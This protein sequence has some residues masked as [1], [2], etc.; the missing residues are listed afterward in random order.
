MN[1]NL[2]NAVQLLQEDGVR[3]ILSV[4]K[5]AELI[6]DKLE[7]ADI[8]RDDRIFY[9]GIM[10]HELVFSIFPYTDLDE[11]G[12]L[13]LPI[14]E[15]CGEHHGNYPPLIYDKLTELRR[16]FQYNMNH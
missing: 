15:E 10:K 11:S 6:F 2:H 14:C 5:I 3:E 12:T 4:L 7:N 9:L 1:I 8:D 16:Y 13:L